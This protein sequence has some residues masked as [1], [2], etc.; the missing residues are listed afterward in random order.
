MTGLPQNLGEA[1]RAYG[2]LT[3]NRKA[4]LITRDDMLTGGCMC[5]AVRYEAEADL[6]GSVTCNCSRCQ[7]LGWTLAFTTAAQFTL[8]A[9]EESLT[10]VVLLFNNSIRPAPPWLPSPAG[11]CALSREGR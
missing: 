6:D 10:R 8:L 11:F 2:E 4:E 1:A 5:G 9:G 3:K 7:K